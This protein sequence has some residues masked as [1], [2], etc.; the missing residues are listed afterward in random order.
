[1]A[2]VLRGAP[3]HQVALLDGDDVVAAALSVPLRWDGTPDGLPTGWDDAV[4]RAARLL[5]DGGRPDAV[6]A[7]SITMAPQMTGR[8]RRPWWPRSRTRR[9]PP[10]SRH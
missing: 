5:E 9:P 8:C 6:S 7:L 10:G 4:V 1:M 3:A 2:G